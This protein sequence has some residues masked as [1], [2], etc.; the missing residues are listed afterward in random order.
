M[1]KKRKGARLITVND[2]DYEWFTGKA[3]TNIRQLETRRSLNVPNTDIAAR[4]FVANPGA[5]EEI[6]TEDGNVR[7]ITIGSYEDVVSTFQVSEWI[8]ANEEAF[9]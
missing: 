6:L 2:I 1:T 4:I 3:N 9:I 5:I 7:T 8:K